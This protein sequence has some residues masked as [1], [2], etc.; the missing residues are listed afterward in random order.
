MSKN[1]EL[2]NLFF[3]DFS[4]QEQYVKWDDAGRITI[5]F[6]QLKLLMT[7]IM[8]LTIFWNQKELPKPQVVIVGAA[9]GHHYPILAKMFP[10][11]TF[12]LYDPRRFDI[13]LPVERIRLYNDYFTDEDAVFWSGRS[14][15]IFISDIRSID[16]DT[17]AEEYE[18]RVR[19]DMEMQQ[20]WVEIINPVAASLKFRLEYPLEDPVTKIANVDIISEYLDGY[21]MKQIWAPQTST[22]V[23]LI[24]VKVNGKYRKKKWSSLL[25]QNQCFFHNRR[26]RPS[27]FYNPFTNDMTP[28]FGDDLT[29]DFDSVGTALILQKY[30]FKMTGKSPDMNDA[31]ALYQVLIED[32]NNHRPSYLSVAQLRSAE[33]KSSIN[34][35]AED[36]NWLKKTIPSAKYKY[37]DY[38]SV[39]TGHEA[40]RAPLPIEL[41]R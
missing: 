5:H 40:P 24:P 17:T 16:K 10:G 28:I 27:N 38:I 6:G 25:H 36:K 31:V 26:I 23:R 20:R 34:K 13:K 39:I 32:I 7:D 33:W 14:D 41:L 4:P 37:R 21:R 2:R 9:P 30:L 11:A 12:H 19:I 1:V 3:S 8:F 15:V 22:E 29:N 35:K 18:G